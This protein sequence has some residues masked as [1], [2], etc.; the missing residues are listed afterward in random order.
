MI[1]HPTNLL[2]DELQKAG[3]PNADLHGLVARIAAAYNEA[4]PSSAP[5]T[6]EGRLGEIELVEPEGAEEMR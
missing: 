6:P 3:I 4:N 2:L 5:P 1:Q